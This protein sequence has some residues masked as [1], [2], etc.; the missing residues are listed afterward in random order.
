MGN[1]G[2]LFDYRHLLQ[3]RALP[4]APPA[5]GFFPPLDQL[6]RNVSPTV[7]RKPRAATLEKLATAVLQREVRL[8]GR[9]KF[10]LPLGL[11][12]DLLVRAQQAHPP[13]DAAFDVVSWTS[14]GVLEFVKR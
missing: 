13:Q 11:K 9:G 1:G 10:H 12:R 3:W 7:V 8:L 4:S 2:V 14:A 5:L 6:V